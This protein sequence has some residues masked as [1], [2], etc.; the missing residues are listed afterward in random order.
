MCENG[1]S[2][3]ISFVGAVARATLT[4]IVITQ[5]CGQ[6]AGDPR[7]ERAT[8]DGRDD[9]CSD[10]G[11]GFTDGRSCS[12]LISAI[13][14]VQFCR[15]QLVGKAYKAVPLQDNRGFERRQL[16]TRCAQSTSCK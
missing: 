13:C 16:G 7:L 15:D 14:D 6:G 1:A 2:L 5:R 9:Q 11:V 12:R 10:E 3:T 4:L 8:A